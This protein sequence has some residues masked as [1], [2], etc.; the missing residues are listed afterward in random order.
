MK[1]NRIIALLLVLVMSAALVLT[2][3]SKV[4]KADV[5]DDPAGENAKAVKTTI[6]AVGGSF[7]PVAEPFENVKDSGTIEVT[8]KNDD[9]G[10]DATGSVA[11]DLKDSRYYGDLN[12]KLGEAALSFKLFGDKNDI[13]FEAPELFEGAYGISFETLV[14]DIKNTDLFGDVD[15]DKAADAVESL[16]EMRD[17]LAENDTTELTEKFDLLLEKLYEALNK[18]DHTV[19]KKDVMSG[20]EEVGAIVTE[21]KFDEGD[22]VNVLKAFRDNGEDFISELYKM[23]TGYYAS[24]YSSRGIDVPEFDY[25]K[26]EDGIDEVIDEV[27][28]F[29]FDLDLTVALDSMTGQIIR[30][31]FTLEGSE[32]NEKIEGELDFG[33]DLEDFSSITGE[34][35]IKDHNTNYKIELDMKR[36]DDSSEFTE[37]INFKFSE[38]YDHDGYRSDETIKF[39]FDFE[40]DK[41]AKTYTLDVEGSEEYSRNGYENNSSGSQEFSLS[42]S[43][44]LDY[45]SKSLTI[46]LDTLSISENDNTFVDLEDFGLTV[47]I[48]NGA[49]FEDVPEY[50]NILGMDQDD[51]EALGEEINENAK[52]MSDDIKDFGDSFEEYFEG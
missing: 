12:A 6:S 16:L 15:L 43:G 26:I 20:G 52:A 2:S 47:K 10:V 44:A 27:E 51:I 8:W 23:Y 3:C 48:T 32:E 5:E 45:G 35:T 1:A 7:A 25:D 37:S 46:G 21:F 19:E 38:K 18:A 49:D 50:T 36:S 41:D 17:K 34:V 40:N 13:A 31:D 28:D 4:S 29:D 22:V 42:A 24:I 14:D 30:I 33:R 39:S 11:Y 9:I